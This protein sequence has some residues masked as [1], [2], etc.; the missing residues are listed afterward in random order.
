MDAEVLP[1]SSGSFSQDLTVP[2]VPPS[3]LSNCSII[4]LKYVLK[5]SLG[6]AFEDNAGILLLQLCKLIDF[7][8]QIE[9]VVGGFHKNL[10]ARIPIVMGTIPLLTGP[11]AYKPGGMVVQPTQPLPNPSSPG[12]PAPAPAPATTPTPAQ[13]DVSPAPPVGGGWNLPSPGEPGMLPPANGS[14]APSAP[15]LYPQLRMYF[16]NWLSCDYKSVH[17]A[18]GS[19]F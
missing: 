9:A 11:T 2:A 19:H 17:L 3:N 8:F 5:V 12:V 4:D 18:F 16:Q 6:F 14:V 7:L 15:P 13:R 1:H 10:S